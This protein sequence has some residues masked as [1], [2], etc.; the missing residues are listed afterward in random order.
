M[1]TPLTAVPIVNKIQIYKIQNR[2]N[3]GLEEIH[4]LGK[5]NEGMPGMPGQSKP[6]AIRSTFF[7]RSKLIGNACC[8]STLLECARGAEP[9]EGE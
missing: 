1:T 7:L 3:I 2:T 8:P 4:V 5:Y 6:G 9:A